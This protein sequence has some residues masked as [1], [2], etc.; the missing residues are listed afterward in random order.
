MNTLRVRVYDVGFG[1]AVLIS[2]PDAP[3]G[4]EAVMRHILI[5][6]GNAKFSAE[7]GEG[8]ID[9][10]FEPVVRDVLDAIDGQPL[11]LYI[12]THEHWDHVQ[13]LP[14]AD[15]VVFPDQSLADLLA[16]R[17]SWLTASA[18]PDYEET[19]PKAGLARAE[20]R[21]VYEEIERFLAAEGKMDPFIQALMVNNNRSA[22]AYYVDRLRL[23]AD[24]AHTHYVHRPR[25]G[26]PEDAIGGKHPFQEAELEVW[27]PEEDT[28]GYFRRLHPMALNVTPA[29]DEGSVPQLTRVTPPGGVDAGAFYNLVDS[30]RRTYL[31]NLLAIDRAGNDTSIVLLLSWRGWRLLFAGDAQARSWRMMGEQG[32][33]RDVHF[34]KVSHHGSHNGMPPGE[35]LDELLPEEPPDG[36]P[37]YAVVSTCPHT[38]SNVPHHPTLDALRERAVVYS[39]KEDVGDRGYLY[40]DFLFEGDGDE[41]KVEFGPA[42]RTFER[43]AL[44]W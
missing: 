42:D 38:Y 12:M 14:Y 24:E 35:L 7:G 16:V 26:C 19:H 41:V 40:V 3:P 25:A 33:L 28:A 2:V 32:V 27:A 31:D 5:D 23:L 9:D 43:V 1:D 8:H 39:T 21:E 6:V 4:D 18:A 11:D 10:V 22:T 20:A 44:L 30:R 15:E 37:R 36:K 34:L 13:G 17:H 29:G